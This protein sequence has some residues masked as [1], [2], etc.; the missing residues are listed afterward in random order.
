VKLNKSGK[1]RVKA[2]T[3]ANEDYIYDDARYKQGLSLYYKEE[4]NSFRELFRKYFNRN[5][6]NMTN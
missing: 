2:Y 4:F 6:K 3:K 5:N 1:L